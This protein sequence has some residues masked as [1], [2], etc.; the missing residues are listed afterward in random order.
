ME[1][2]NIISQ[3]EADNASAFAISQEDAD[4]LLCRGS[5]IEK[6]KYRI[7]EHFL[8]GENN[9][10]N[11][12]FLKNEY[13]IGGTY[14]ALPNIKIDL[15]YDS[16]GLHISRGSLTKPD[17]QFTLSWPKAAKR[18]ACLIRE[19]RY[20]S[21]DEKA[22]FADYRQEEE[23]R[24]Q[25][26]KVA[27]EFR[28]VVYEFNEFMADTGEKEKQLNLWVM[29]GCWTAFSVGE[30]KTYTR[31]TKG[32]FVL[33]LMRDTMKSIIAENTY[34][35]R[36]CEDIMSSLNSELAKPL[37]PSFAELNPLPPPKTEYRYSLGDEV[38]IGTARYKILAINDESAVLYD[39]AFPLLNKEMPRAE[40]DA[41]VRE[42]PFNDKY[43]FIVEENPELE[44]AKALI[45][46]YCY[47]EYDTPP[48]FSDLSAID[49]AY[50]TTEEHELPIQVSV[51][52]EHFRIDTLLDDNLVRRWQ[53][54]SL[55]RLI[56]EELEGL[57]FN[58]LVGIDEEAKPLVAMVEY[59]DSDGNAGYCSQYSDAEKLAEDIASESDSGVPF[60]LVIYRDANGRTIPT[61]FVDRLDPP[62]KGLRYENL[63]STIFE[64]ETE[65]EKQEIPDSETIAGAFEAAGYRR[66]SSP[67]NE[68]IFE[69]AIGYPLTFLDW[70][71]AYRFINEAELKLE[72]EAVRKNVQKIL[73]PE[74][75]AEIA[76]PPAPQRKPTADITLHP[77]ITGVESLNFRIADDNL[78]VGTPG[79]R[80]LNNIAAIRLLKKL[81]SEDRLASAE[82][83]KTLS[84]YVGWGGLSECFEESSSHYSELKS[85]LDGDEYIAVR[86]STLTA[87]YTPPVVIC[88]MYSAL[89]NMGFK[90]GNILDEA[91]A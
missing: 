84:A 70:D 45:E 89:E 14:P 24:A 43:K 75:T 60:S 50:T 13:G 64:L 23:I 46:Q 8:K 77:E 30:K 29:S 20:L 2:Q 44:R 76:P 59:L 71:T 19:D 91:V 11:S 22:G 72:P 83:Q 27:E 32:D 36:R 12:A 41:K 73:H 86:E 80:Y 31:D 55:D 40:F 49:I 79:Q 87:F 4:A 39:S 6:G 78:G 3:A 16:K 68:I 18:I 15:S 33:P 1:Q 10:A 5:G 56:H 9:D 51:D 52:L 61:D 38:H 57:D 48:D 88:S 90:T 34:L 17:T 67:N 7:Y 81:E 58:E 85:L 25:R 53:Y 69:D 28:S 26:N 47:D 63:T 37:E 82:E 54:D 62:P 65:A 21:E 42:N 74:L 35:T 66:G